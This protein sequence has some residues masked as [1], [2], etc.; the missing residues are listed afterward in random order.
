MRMADVPQEQW[1]SVLAARA[2][3]AEQGYISLRLREYQ[4]SWAELME[5][6]SQV[7]R[8]RA[9]RFMMTSVEANLATLVGR[10]GGQLAMAAKAAPQRWRPGWDEYD[11][12]EA[13]T[14]GGTFISEGTPG[15]ADAA[16]LEFPDPHLSLR[17]VSHQSST[18]WPTVRYSLVPFY[19]AR[20][21]LGRAL[22]HAPLG[23]A[24][25]RCDRNLQ[26]PQAGYV[27]QDATLG[28]TIALI[29]DARSDAAKV[30]PIHLSGLVISF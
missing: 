2:V 29:S 7:S 27:A 12:I 23:R 13:R 5:Q 1:R 6:N 26:L 10:P 4:T 3:A 9:S 19:R 8:E 11:D 21:H 16:G 18:R 15:P 22:L 24:R 28:S 30:N 17:L 14:S 25:H 20:H